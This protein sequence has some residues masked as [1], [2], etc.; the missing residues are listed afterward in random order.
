MTG[1][2]S[3]ISQYQ[4]SGICRMTTDDDS[5]FAH[6]QELEARPRFYTEENK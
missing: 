5:T 1:C 2:R 6:Q 3:D 4:S